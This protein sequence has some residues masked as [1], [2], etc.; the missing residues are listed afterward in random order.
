MDTAELIEALGAE[1]TWSVYSPGGAP[2]L[3]QT[4]I[5][6]LAFTETLVFKF[7]KSV[8]F[9][10]LDY[11][12]LERRRRFC[13]EEVRLNRRLAPSLYLGVV[14]LTRHPG[15]GCRVGEASEDASEEPG[16]VLEWAVCMHRLPKAR[17]LEALLESG[18]VD[19]ARIEE[20]AQ[21]LAD[22][23]GRAARGPEGTHGSTA[24]VRQNV[25]ENFEQLAPFADGLG[26]GPVLAHLE[27]RARGFMERERELFE[28]R[29]SAHV[30]EGHGDLHAS[31]VC[32][33]PSGLAIYDCIEFSA[34]LRW[35]DVACDLAFLTMDLDHR[36]LG[37]FGSY[38]ARR[39]AELA[40]DVEL[41]L[42]IGFYGDYRAVVRAKVAAF[43]AEQA[44]QAEADSEVAAA[45]R[46]E[47]QGYLALAGRAGLA[48]ALILT[49]GLPASGKSTLARH[50]ALRF[51]AAH[52]SS[53]IRR[54]QLAGMRRDEDAH[55]AYGEGIYSPEGKAATYASLLGSARKV[56]EAGRSVLVDASFPRADDRG[57]FVELAR[58]LEAP[59]LV[60][61][62]QVDEAATRRRMILRAEDPGEAADANL[63]VWEH[64]RGD[65]EVP[66]EIASGSVVRITSGEESL[67]R[68]ALKVL[69][70]WIRLRPAPTT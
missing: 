38:L 66:S 16:D 31:N 30:R 58:E 12:T 9:G 53:D 32:F 2:E 69:D 67:E 70:A 50:M 18:E 34:R 36:G 27:A 59:L 54:K 49:C 39:Y 52:L 51:D 5:S 21:C 33:A 64:A 26:A 15:G 43:A 17:M 7:K 48:P 8:D 45:K 57:E 25:L 63:A 6:V 4:H 14:A 62:V 20:L 28:R 3:L 24:E 13:L 47:A 23:H 56:L 19:N 41:G 10:F 55:A 44:E 22:F 61:W 29:E 35:G 1:S 68:D 11:S 42:V 37:A 60:V 65:F 40:G 46:R